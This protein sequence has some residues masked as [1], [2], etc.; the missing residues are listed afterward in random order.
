MKP[1]TKLVLRANDNMLN[2][3]GE[4]IGCLIVW[5]AGIGMFLSIVCA[6]LGRAE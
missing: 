1:A 3:V 4:W 6:L 5:C 2:E